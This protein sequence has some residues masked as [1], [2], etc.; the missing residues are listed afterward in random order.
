[1][2]SFSI[3]SSRDVSGSH[4]GKYEVDC[5]LDT[6][7]C[8]I[9]EADLYS[10]AHTAVRNVGLLQRDCTALYPRT[11]SFLTYLSSQIPHWS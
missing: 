2:F 11:L 3:R 4:R 7:P 10:E 9:A 5:L 1:M 6:E 8:C